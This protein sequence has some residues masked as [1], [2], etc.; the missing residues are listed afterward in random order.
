VENIPKAVLAGIAIKVGM[1]IID[2]GFLR[3]AHLVSKRGA[4]IMYSVILMTVFMDLITAVGIGLFVA[5][6]LTIRRLADLQSEYVR[7][8]EKQDDAQE[9]EWEKMQPDSRRILL[10]AGNGVTLLQ[11]SGPLIF[12]AAQTL[13]RQQ[14]LLAEAKALVIDMS[15]VPHIGVSTALVLERIIRDLVQDGGSVYLAGMQEQPAKRFASLGLAHWTPRENWVDDCGEAL[16]RAQD[17]ASKIP[18]NS[19]HGW[20]GGSAQTIS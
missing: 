1:D 6:I 16:K 7:V 19:S 2:W 10:D 18:E 8:I 4:I 5:N 17:Q 12:G 15:E 11:L 14:T 13:T 9:D 3:R 20:S